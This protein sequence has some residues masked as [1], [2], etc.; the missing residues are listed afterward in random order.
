MRHAGVI[1]AAGMTPEQY[2][3]ETG[4]CDMRGSSLL[5]IPPNRA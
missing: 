4:I 5:H 1:R 3:K 2:R